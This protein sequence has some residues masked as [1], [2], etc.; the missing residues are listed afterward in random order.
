MRRRNVAVA[1]M[2]G[3]VAV[4]TTVA[5]APAPAGAPPD[6]L[7]VGFPSGPGA[8]PLAIHSSLQPRPAAVD[9]DLVALLDVPIDSLLETRILLAA[10]ER[11]Q[12]LVVE[13]DTGRLAL[14]RT[15][16]GWSVV[17]PETLAADPVLVRA[18][19]RNLDNERIIAWRRDLARD[20][21]GLDPPRARLLFEFEGPVAHDEILIGGDAPGGVFAQFAGDSAVFVVRATLLGIL[22]GE[23]SRLETRQILATPIDAAQSLTLT[24]D[25]ETPLRLARRPKDAGDWVDERGRLPASRA[26]E[27]AGFLSALT[28]V[29]R[30]P[31]RDDAALLG[32]DAAVVSVVWD[33]PRSGHLEIADPL[34][35]DRRFGRVSLAAGTLYL[36][37]Q[38]DI[39]SLRRLATP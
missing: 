13:R 1:A 27:V 14:E 26:G 20:A 38:S 32:F 34:D 16:E 17:A 33:G 31:M 9:L 29:D 19:L 21:A 3:T 30:L 35:P 12:R 8:V 22:P 39:D 23:A 6:T 36:F 7:L 24:F 11:V 18:L 28:P 10:P 5:V 37:L 15:D 25:R 2:L 4:A